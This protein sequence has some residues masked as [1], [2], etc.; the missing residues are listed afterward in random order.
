MS[1][2]SSRELAQSIYDAHHEVESGCGYRCSCGQKFTI[3]NGKWREDLER[4][5]VEEAAAALDG[6][7][8]A[9]RR[10]AEGSPLLRLVE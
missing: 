5:L 4:H 7:V 1:L 8:S 6:F 3:A 2:P 10:E 9:V